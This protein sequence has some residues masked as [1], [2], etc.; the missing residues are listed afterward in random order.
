MSIDHVVLA[1]LGWAT[2]GCERNGSS[3]IIRSRPARTLC[4]HQFIGLQDD[5]FER[6]AKIKVLAAFKE[7]RYSAPLLIAIKSLAPLLRCSVCRC[8]G[9]NFPGGASAYTI[10]NCNETTQLIDKDAILIPLDMSFTSNGPASKNEMGVLK[11]MIM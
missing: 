2:E 10:E 3:E 8:L 11:N 7:S 6:A 4:A 1:C 9:G 5:V